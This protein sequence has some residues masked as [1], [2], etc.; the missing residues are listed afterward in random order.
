MSPVSGERIVSG[1]AKTRG[2]VFINLHNKPKLID[3][4]TSY[5][6]LKEG[7]GGR[8]FIQKCLR[9]PLKGIG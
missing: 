9:G 6:N 1:T 2:Q 4:P 5:I 7:D 3:E 8:I